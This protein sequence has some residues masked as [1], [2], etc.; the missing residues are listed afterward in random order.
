MVGPSINL[1]YYALKK[2]WPDAQLRH[3][4]LAP[5]GDFS[6]LQNLLCIS[7][8]FSASPNS[9]SSVTWL[10][11]ILALALSPELARA[12]RICTL[13]EHFSLKAFAVC[14]TLLS[15]PYSIVL[16][17][18]LIPGL[19][20]LWVLIPGTIVCLSI[21]PYLLRQPAM[22]ELYDSDEEWECME[23]DLQG[24]ALERPLRLAGA[25]RT[26]AQRCD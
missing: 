4:T 18:T 2:G 7:R 25:T 5:A 14:F 13:R 20:F 11:V 1:L 21:S 3:T 8:L 26:T 16:A 23:V 9:K 19:L 10:S 15:L 17:S 24:T 12:T 6:V 22:E